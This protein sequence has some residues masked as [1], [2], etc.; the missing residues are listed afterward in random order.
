MSGSGLAGGR[1]EATR[2]RLV[3]VAWLLLLALL[4]ALSVATYDKAFDGHVTAS[5]ETPRAGLQLN[6]GGDVR[7]NGAIVGRVSHIEATQDGAVVQVQLDGDAARRIPDSAT[8]RILPTTLFGQKYV[9]LSSSADPGKGHVEDGTVLRTAPGSDP[10]ELTRVLDHL[11]GVLSSVQPQ[12]LSAMLQATAYGL[13]GQGAAMADLMDGAGSYLT[14][15]NAMA[16]LFVRDLQLLERVTKAYAGDVPHLLQVLGNVTTTASTM[17][18]GTRWPTFL[19]S[20]TR[21]ASAGEQL[22]RANRRQLHESAML[23]RPTLELLREYSPEIPCSIIGFLG[24]R[25][26]SAAQIKG[27]SVAGYFTFGKQVD[28]YSRDDR[29]VLGDLGTGPSCR[30]LPDPPIPY[31]AIDLHDGV[32]EPGP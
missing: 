6:V 23:S 32:Q 1:A 28:G 4:V 7:M 25:D 11:E 5:I 21:A 3:G 12:K 22:L 17:T 16:P 27:A 20:V 18:Q 15:L 10:V 19:G 9:E 2:L 24:V 30:G 29:L 26:S 8:A 31:P 13:D 14:R